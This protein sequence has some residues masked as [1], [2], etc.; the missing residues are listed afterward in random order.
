MVQ[1]YHHD[2]AGRLLWRTAEDDGPGLPPSSRVFVSPY[3]TTAR[4]AQHGHIVSC[5]G[6][7]THLTETCTPGSPIVITDV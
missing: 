4:Y 3:D 6:L 7:S 1:N 2:A 5:R